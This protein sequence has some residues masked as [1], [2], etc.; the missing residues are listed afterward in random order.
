MDSLQRFIDAQ[1]REY[2][3]ALREIKN[4]KKE[5]HWIWYIFPQLDG[6]G[7][8]A[9][10]K[11]YSI[12]GIKEAN[13][14]YNN[15][16]LKNHLIEI[17]NCLLNLEN[18]NIRD[19]MGYPDYLKLKSCMTLFYHVSGNE[20]FKEVLTKYYDGKQDIQTLKLLN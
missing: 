16:Y 8:S 9:T 1:E 2:K 6:L 14:Y 13:S 11:Y 19:I 15:E 10:S 12:K 5:S 7:K 18:D 20:I 4:G 3:I 17:T